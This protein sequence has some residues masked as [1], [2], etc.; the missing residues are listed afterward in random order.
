MALEP[1]LKNL[2]Q[3]CQSRD[4][5]QTMEEQDTEWA[6]KSRAGKSPRGVWAQMPAWLEERAVLGIEQ[7]VAVVGDFD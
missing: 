1:R 3:E 7:A 6:E 4:I 5:G 2:C